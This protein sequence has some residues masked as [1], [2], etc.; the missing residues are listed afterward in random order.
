MPRIYIF[1]WYFTDNFLTFH[2]SW[3]SSLV[4]VF[5]G[6]SAIFLST[7]C[8][9][10]KWQILIHA[11]S[12][13]Q[14]DKEF[15]SNMRNVKRDHKVKEYLHYA[16]VNALQKF[17][18]PISSWLTF[19]FCGSMFF[20][21]FGQKSFCVSLHHQLIGMVIEI[22]TRTNKIFIYFCLVR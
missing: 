15:Q 17:L 11:D 16:F 5:T 8:S 2:N 13:W 22:I 10:S 20:D 19:N 6:T 14:R 1:T 12:K 3:D 21:A 9:G 18:I 7:C 4:A